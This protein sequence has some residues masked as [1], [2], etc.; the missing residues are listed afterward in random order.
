VGKCDRKRRS[1][2]TTEK[3]ETPSV[4]IVRENIGEMHARS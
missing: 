4:S 3:K 1:I 2:G